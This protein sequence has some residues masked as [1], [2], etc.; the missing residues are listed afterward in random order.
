MKTIRC[1][2]FV[3]ALMIS[4]C[5]APSVT[6]ILP[7][8]QT[9]SQ[10][11]TFTPTL[12]FSPTPFPTLTLTATATLT[13]LPP[14][15][16][17]F[18]PILYR[19]YVDRYYS[20]QVLGGIQ[21]GEWVTDEIAMQQIQFDKTYNVYGLEGFIGGMNIVNDTT[22]LDPPFCGTYYVG[23]D[24][25]QNLDPLF[26]F[27]QGWDVTIRPFTEIA[28]DTPV[29][30]QAV[31]EWLI[32][33]GIAQPEVKITRILRTDIEG[34]GIDEVFIA[35]TR[36][37]SYSMPVTEMGDYS[38][39]L[40]RKVQ[41]NEVVTIPLAADVYHSLQSEPTYPYTYALA[42]FFDLNQDANLEVILKVN[43]WEGG[44]I[45]VYEVKDKNTL[46]VLTEICAE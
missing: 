21:N 31:A 15:L 42:G 40:M 24:M 29:Y 7:V 27:V 44:G 16:S 10:P 19:Q 23:S 32:S 41:G 8:I 36:F 28:V 38:I 30:Q 17:S 34:D 46:Q 37:I 35:A 33:Q 1:L 45:I 39:I 13:P 3:C 22:S 18:S 25:S 20:F 4:A 14:P 2:I 11:M 5:G 6:P 26:G 9:S 12:T 43:R